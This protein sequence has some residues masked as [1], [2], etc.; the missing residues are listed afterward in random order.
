MG[1]A[2]RIKQRTDEKIG[3]FR[4]QLPFMAEVFADELRA[5][6]SKAGTRANP[7]RP[8]EAPHMVTGQLVN[9]IVTEIYPALDTALVGTTAQ[10]GKYL[11]A[12]R[13]Y[14]NITADRCRKKMRDIAFDDL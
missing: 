8:G 7:S 11:V 6:L 2:E 5:V 10:H 14:L 13:P 4:E 1:L 3:T 9:S 12:T